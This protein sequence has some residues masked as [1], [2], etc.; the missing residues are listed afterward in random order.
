M[1]NLPKTESPGE[2]IRGLI[3]AQDRATLATKMRAGQE[4]VEGVGAP[5]ASLVLMGS[6]PDAAPLLL[7]STLADHTKNLLADP[8]CSLMVDGTKGLTDPLTGARATLQGRLEKTDD[9]GLMERYIRRHPS[10]AMY[11][12]FGDFS[13]YRMSVQ[14]AHLVAGFG[15][16]HWVGAED[17]LYDMAGSGDL[18]Q[19]EGGVVDHMNDDHGDAVGLYA[20]VLLNRPGVGWRMTG[21]DPEGAD[22]RRDGDIARLAFDKPVSDAESA[23]V[24]LV[25]LVKRA[26]KG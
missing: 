13:L 9:R 6:G 21:V 1:E 14:R 18:A 20:N 11:A 17:V 8:V 24:E 25:R 7:L 2:I 19:Q 4:T 15:R 22:L 16:I 12:G 3:R 5:Y 10:A 23:R 26:R